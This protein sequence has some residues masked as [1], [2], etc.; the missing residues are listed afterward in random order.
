MTTTNTKFYKQ[1][2]WKPQVGSIYCVM[3]KDKNKL[4]LFY[5][6][7]ELSIHNSPMKY[8]LVPTNEAEYL[9]ITFK[10]YDYRHTKNVNI[11]Y[12]KLQPICINH[13]HA[14]QDLVLYFQHGHG[15]DKLA[16]HTITD[17]HKPIVYKTAEDTQAT[18]TKLKKLL[19]NNVYLCK[20]NNFDCNYKVEEFYTLYNIFWDGQIFW[21]IINPYKS[22]YDKLGCGEHKYDYYEYTKQKF[23]E[24]CYFKNIYEELKTPNQDDAEDE[25]SVYSDDSDDSDDSDEVPKVAETDEEINMF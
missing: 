19:I 8:G 13:K 22:L 25:A 5:E 20:Y 11:Y 24:M 7:A 9:H 10:V 16:T 12:V 18:T 3:D 15:E 14:K 2:N 21:Q 6:V 23:N 17:A 1:M 4:D